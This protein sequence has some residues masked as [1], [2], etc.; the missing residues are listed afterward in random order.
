M[1]YPGRDID[2]GAKKVCDLRYR[3]RTQNLKV[4]AEETIGMCEITCWV[5]A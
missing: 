2:L 4:K 5:A 3:N 1:K